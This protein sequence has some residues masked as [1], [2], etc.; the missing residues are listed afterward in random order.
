ML[1]EVIADAHIPVAYI[2]VDVFLSETDTDGEED[3]V[4]KSEKD[5][6]DPNKRGRDEV[7]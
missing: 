3:D 1:K 6:S 2:G 5:E 4:E 7:V